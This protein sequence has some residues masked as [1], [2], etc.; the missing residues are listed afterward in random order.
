MC[1]GPPERVVQTMERFAAFLDGQR[2]AE[3]LL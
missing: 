2:V 3:I 1:F